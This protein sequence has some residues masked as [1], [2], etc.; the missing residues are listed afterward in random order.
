ME[1][2]KTEEL[3]AFFQIREDAEVR[4]K[5]QRMKSDGRLSCCC[6]GCFVE[7]VVG[8]KA[9]YWRIESRERAAKIVVSVLQRCNTLR[10]RR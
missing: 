9:V 2:Q 10:V 4:H 3:H 6:D 5:E 1:G 8:L 7:A